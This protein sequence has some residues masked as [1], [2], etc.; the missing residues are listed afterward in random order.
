VREREHESRERGRGKENPQADSL[1]RA[2]PEV[3]NPRTLRS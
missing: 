2:E 1:L 3:V